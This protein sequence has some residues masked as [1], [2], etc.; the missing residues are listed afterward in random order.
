MSFT[1]SYSD[2]ERTQAVALFVELVN[3]GMN[4]RAAGDTVAEML[5]PS[6]STV[7]TWAKQDQALVPPTFGDLAHYRERAAS[8][9][10]RIEA[11][12]ADNDA[13]RAQLAAARR[14][15]STHDTEIG[16]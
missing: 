6:R 8:L 16:G 14:T 3:S 11:L 1:R 7:S 10:Q 9:E 12:S 15:D 4:R 2:E 13:L 5:G